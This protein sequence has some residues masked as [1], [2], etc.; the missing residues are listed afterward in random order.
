G[1]AT[2]SWVARDPTADLA[3]LVDQ[4]A[5]VP[6]FASGLDFS[7]SRHLPLRRYEDFLVKEGV[8]AGAAAVVA[9]LQ[10]DVDHARLLSTIE[11]V[12]EE[13]YGLESSIE[14]GPNAAPS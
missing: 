11:A 9:A 7:E 10:T 3:G 12:Y 14:R 1:I 8:G 13:I 4:I 6:V 2:T 5:D